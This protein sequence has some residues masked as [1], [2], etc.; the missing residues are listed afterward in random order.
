MKFLHTADWQIGKPFQ[1]TSDPS[2][3]EALRSQRIATIRAFKAVIDAQQAE[4][5]IVA[6]D[7]FDSFTP[8]QATVSALCAAIGSLQVP[9]YAIPGNHDHGGPGCIWKQDFFL[10]EQ[11]AL[12]S[13]FHILLTPEPVI[14]EHAVLLPCPLL[15][16]HESTDPTA[17]LQSLDLAELPETLPRIVIAHG[18]TQGFSSSGESDSD[19]STNTLELNRISDAHADYIALG[20]WHGTK[21]ISSKAWFAGTPEQDRYAKGEQNEPGHVLV[22]TIPAHQT[23]PLVEKVRTG[24]IGWHQIEQ[25]FGSDADLTELESRLNDSLAGQTGKDLLKLSL[26]G[27]L[28]LAGAAKLDQQLESLQARLINLRLNRELTVEPSPEE[29]TALTQ[30]D[31]PLIA[32]I[33]NELQIES[34]SNDPQTATQAK[35]ALREL[36][37]LLQTI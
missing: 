32:A 30:R 22:V 12:A 19:H 14:I 3:R 2:K 29:L 34:Q 13:N 25:H 28:S 35:D 20:D 6:G 18:S 11:A 5:V 26:T 21:Q 1:S 23:A 24:V 27:T 36:H 17:W 4:F 37:I 31:D 7:L 9:V 33:A 16:R 15:R 10:R 8:D